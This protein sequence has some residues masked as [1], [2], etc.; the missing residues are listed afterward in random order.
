MSTPLSLDFSAL[1]RAREVA[2]RID[3]SPD[4]TRLIKAIAGKASFEECRRLYETGVDID[5]ADALY[6]TAI[7]DRPAM[8]VFIDSRDPSALTAALRLAYKLRLADEQQFERLLALVPCP[9]APL[10]DSFK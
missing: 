1:P 6:A 2:R 10:R 4:H 3:V 8:R 5:P 9:S 7:Y